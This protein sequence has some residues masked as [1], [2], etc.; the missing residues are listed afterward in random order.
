MFGYLCNLS[1]K[2]VLGP[3]FYPP[4]ERTQVRLY[5]L[6][7]GEIVEE[8]RG[9]YNGYGAVYRPAEFHRVCENGQ[10]REVVQRDA[11]KKDEWVKWV[12]APDTETLRTAA[13]DDLNTGMAAALEVAV[14]EQE[15]GWK[16]SRTSLPDPNYAWPF[17]DDDD[18]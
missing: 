3:N 13:H 9:E 18:F 17:G 11:D 10:W 2:A 1:G 8:M 5:Y 4:K 15:E 12:R 7:D 6:I 16:P 14:L